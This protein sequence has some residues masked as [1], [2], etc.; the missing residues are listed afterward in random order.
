MSAL[1]HKRTFAAQNAVSA[2][3]PK[4]DIRSAQAYVR[5]VPLADS[6]I[7]A[8][9]SHSITSSARASGIG[10]I[11]RDRASLRRFDPY[12]FARSI[13]KHVATIDPL[14]LRPLWL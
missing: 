11:S 5:L 12:F 4:A 1:G 10:G 9:V 14:G 3:P 6:C 8:K 13:T 2:L 7:A